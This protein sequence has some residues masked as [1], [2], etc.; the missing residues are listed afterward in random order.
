ME[1][2]AELG[3]FQLNAE[4]LQYSIESV[5][6]RTFLDWP[7]AL[8]QT[9]EQL[10]DAGFFYTKIGDRVVC[11]NCGLGLRG[12]EIDDD[13]W[14]EHARFSENCEYVNL[15]KGKKF[16]EEAKARKPV[17]VEQPK[18]SPEKCETQSKIVSP[19]EDSDTEKCYEKWDEKHREWLNCKICFL[20]EFN[21]VFVSC[22]HMIACAKCASSLSNCPTCRNPFREIIR[23]YFP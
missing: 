10:A 17:G 15:V 12:W 7:K 22:G 23:V 2:H 5:R 1:N 9:P 13:P 19:K 16:I 11:F 3:A 18:P 6:T 21:T 4:F 8:K 14:E 20:N